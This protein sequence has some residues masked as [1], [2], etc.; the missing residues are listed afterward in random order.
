MALP[1]AGSASYLERASSCRQQVDGLPAPSGTREPIPGITPCA[2][3]PMCAYG[4]LEGPLSCR[5]RRTGLRELD[6][7]KEA[8][9]GTHPWFSSPVATDSA[10]D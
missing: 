5:K 4:P 1:G 2:C 6:G 7:G 10:G 8:A 3:C 9:S